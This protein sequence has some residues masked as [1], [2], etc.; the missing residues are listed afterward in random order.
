M[1]IHV[2][3]HG[4]MSFFFIFLFFILFYFFY[5]NFAKYQNE[6]TTGIHMSFFLMAE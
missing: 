6:S 2:V 5:L 1:S 4:I 3:S